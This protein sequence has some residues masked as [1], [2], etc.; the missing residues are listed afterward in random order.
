MHPSFVTSTHLS[1]TQWVRGSWFNPQTRQWHAP[2]WPT[3]RGMPFTT[4]G[5]QAR[6][7]GAPQVA[8]SRSAAEPSW[9]LGGPHTTMGAPPGTPTLP[10]RRRHAAGGLPLWAWY[11]QR[12]ST[13][14]NVPV[15]LR[16]RNIP[17]NPQWSTMSRIRSPSDAFSG[18]HCAP[19]W[20]FSTSRTRLAPLNR[21]RC[22]DCDWC[23][24]VPSRATLSFEDAS[25]CI[26]AT[27]VAKSDT[28]NNNLKALCRG[29]KWPAYAR[30]FCSY[31]FLVLPQ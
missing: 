31:D 3:V 21:P 2:Q 22:V 12:A 11:P 18:R 27:A 24:D 25:F 17:T 28:R 30:M 20:T 26:P 5:G 7:R 15:Y 10:G 8:G 13:P 9:T 6:Q 19:T 29:G 4:L 16:P 14:P 1:V 23:G